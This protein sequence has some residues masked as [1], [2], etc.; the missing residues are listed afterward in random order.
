MGL[1]CLTADKVAQLFGVRQHQR[2]RGKRHGMLEKLD[3]GHPVLR[4]YCQSLVARMY[5]KLAPFLRLEIC[6]NRL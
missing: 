5:E 2:R 3:P 6:V 1:F 4:I